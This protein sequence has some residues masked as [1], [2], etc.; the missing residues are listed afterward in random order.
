MISFQPVKVNEMFL[1]AS[2]CKC[3]ACG[4]ECEVVM[5]MAKQG[6]QVQ[7][8]VF[9]KPDGWD[10][11]ITDAHCPDCRIDVDVQEVSHVDLI[12]ALFDDEVRFR[13]MSN[14]ERADFFFSLPEDAKPYALMKLRGKIDKLKSVCQPLPTAVGQ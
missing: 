4:K 1:I 2:V 8:Q 14:S 6:K 5:T 12:D 7:F 10:I 11:S 13:S 3:D 9:E